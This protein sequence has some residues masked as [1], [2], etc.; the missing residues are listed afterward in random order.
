M[1]WLRAAGS[2]FRRGLVPNSNIHVKELD[3]V[4]ALLP[5]ATVLCINLYNVANSYHEAWM[6]RTKET[7]QRREVE[8]RWLAERRIELV[9][10]GHL[11]T[12]SGP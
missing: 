7:Q 2:N 3:Q 5:G 12:R 4:V 10:F 6:L 8:L 9:R 1:P 11:H